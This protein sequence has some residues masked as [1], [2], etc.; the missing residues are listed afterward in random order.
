MQPAARGASGTSTATFF[1]GKDADAQPSSEFFAHPY[2]LCTPRRF[3]VIPATR[4]HA[5][6]RASQSAIA[7]SLSESE[8]ALTRALEPFAA[9]T[10][11]A[12]DLA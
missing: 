8:A 4:R 11:P 9:F 3:S 5:P 12:G 7:A 10:E 6:F 2:G 1:Q